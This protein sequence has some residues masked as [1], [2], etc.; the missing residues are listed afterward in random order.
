MQSRNK[1]TVI[2]M[3]D[4]FIIRICSL[5]SI[6]DFFQTRLM[7]FRLGAQKFLWNNKIVDTPPADD[8]DLTSMLDAAERQNNLRS[9][10]K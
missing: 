2:K 7:Q 10:L 5:T 6:V 4:L 9:A 8:G 3:T 1:T